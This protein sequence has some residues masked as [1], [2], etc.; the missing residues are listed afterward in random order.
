ME[1]GVRASPVIQVVKVRRGCPRNLLN[2]ESMGA[3]R[4]DRGVL[5]RCQGCGASGRRKIAGAAGTL[6]AVSPPHERN[7]RAECDVM[8]VNHPDRW[9]SRGR[10]NYE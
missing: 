6:P 4:W 2:R 10:G 7:G 1:R 9:A 8:H 3:S 5:A